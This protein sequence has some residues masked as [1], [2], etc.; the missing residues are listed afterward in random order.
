MWEWG[1]VQDVGATDRIASVDADPQGC[2]L[3][4]RCCRRRASGLEPGAW[5][6]IEGLQRLGHVPQ[7]SLVSL[8]LWSLSLSLSLFLSLSLNT[9]THH[10]DVIQG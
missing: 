1:P 8:S 6:R 3:R 10:A 9:H 4:R 7:V 5:V 2:R